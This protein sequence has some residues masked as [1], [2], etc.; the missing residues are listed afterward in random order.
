MPV[1]RV[2][3]LDRDRAAAVRRAPRSRSRRCSCAWRRSRPG[4]R[5]PARRGRARPSTL[6]PG[7]QST[8]DGDAVHGVQAVARRPAAAARSS[9]AA[10]RGISSRVWARASTSSARA[11]R[12]SRAASRSMWPRKRSRSSGESLAPACSTSTALVMAA[13]G[14]RSSCAA[15][16]DELA[17]GALA[18]L[19]LGDVREHDHGAARARLGRD[20]HDREGVV[21][22]GA[23]GRLR[24]AGTGGGRAPP[25][26][27]AARSPP[28][29]RA[30]PRR[31]PGR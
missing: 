20:A 14:V 29:A 8:C 18:A 27:R 1:P 23:H 16:V 22:V 17:L 13:S 9:M 19:P 6:R 5:P 25:P 4:S 7:G 10:R 2:G 31:P 15:F 21:L 12:A 24:D 30:G 11:R 26:A 28:T 3:D